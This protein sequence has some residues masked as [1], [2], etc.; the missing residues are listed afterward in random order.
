MSSSD[1]EL[2]L[3]LDAARAAHQLAYAEA[4]RRVL[5]H[6]P[7]GA[8][9]LASLTN[10]QRLVV[11]RWQAAEAEYDRLRLLAHTRSDRRHTP[12]QEA[13]GRTPPSGRGPTDRR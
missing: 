1:D 12:A 2:A 8:S 7:P 11:Q 6:W 3:A 9:D 13:T 4:R 5:D 10:E